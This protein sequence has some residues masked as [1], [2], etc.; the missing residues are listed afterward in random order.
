MLYHYTSHQLI[1]IGYHPDTFNYNYSQNSYVQCCGIKLSPLRV[2]KLTLL[3]GK[4]STVLKYEL[5]QRRYTA[6]VIYSDE[7]LNCTRDM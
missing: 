5:H 1:L 6:L 7:T 3:R 4:T 2:I